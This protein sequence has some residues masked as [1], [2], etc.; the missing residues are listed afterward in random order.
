[1]SRDRQNQRGIALS[2]AGLGEVAVESK[3]PE[4]G[5]ML[6][7]ASE[8]LFEATGGVMESDDRIPYDRAVASARSKLGDKAFDQAR[9]QGRAMSVESAIEYAMEEN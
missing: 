8:A 9:Q 3:Q 6:L 5:A 1:M 2:L 7:G 4:R